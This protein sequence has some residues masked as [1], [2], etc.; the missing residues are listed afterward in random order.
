MFIYVQVF[1]GR[2]WSRTTFCR[3][4]EGY[5]P[6]RHCHI[7]KYFSNPTHQ[8]L[9]ELDWK[10][11]VKES[12]SLSTSTGFQVHFCVFLRSFIESLERC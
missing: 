7:W 4:Y 2:G 6:H 11:E 9:D 12:A 8:F 3:P 10:V 1:S 5:H